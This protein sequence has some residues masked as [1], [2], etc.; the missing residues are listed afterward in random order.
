MVLGQIMKPQ[1]HTREVRA[2]RSLK[3]GLKSKNPNQRSM[4]SGSL[5]EASLSYRSRTTPLRFQGPIGALGE[6]YGSHPPLN[7]TLEY[8]FYWALSLKSSAL[9]SE[10]WVLQHEPEVHMADLQPTK[11]ILPKATGTMRDRYK[12]H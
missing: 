9:K 6:Q 8:G 1:E 4:H 11:G 2:N 3:E 10:A 12:A 5:R 7:H